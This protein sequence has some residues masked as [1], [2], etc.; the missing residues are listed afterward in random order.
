MGYTSC[1]TGPAIQFGLAI[2][3]Q[4]LFIL[5]EAM[6]NFPEVATP[7]VVQ[8][9]GILDN[10]LFGKLVESQDFL[11]AFKLGDMTLRPEK[12][13][14]THP[15]LLRREYVFYTDLLADTLGVPKYPFSRR[16]QN[17]GGVG[18]GRVVG[19]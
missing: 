19:N 5:N 10:L 1:S 3:L 18:N 11:A 12:R 6:N 16:F 14:S 8:I 17:A 15:D 2:P 9:L 13:G 4:T 7:R